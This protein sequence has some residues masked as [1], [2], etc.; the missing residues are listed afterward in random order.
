MR[1]SRHE[2]AASRLTRRARPAEPESS[3]NSGEH[4]SGVGVQ[5]EAV[6]R[7]AQLGAH[8]L[9]DKQASRATPP[10]LS[11]VV[12][13]RRLPRGVST[14][15]LVVRCERRPCCG[16]DDR[17]RPRQH[18]GVER[19]DRGRRRIHNA[20][21][22]R[23]TAGLAATTEGS[24]FAHLRG[25]EP[26]ARERGPPLT[27]ESARRSRTP[28]RARLRSQPDHDPGVVGRPQPEA[29]VRR[30]VA[31][32]PARSTGSGSPL[33]A[34][35]KTMSMRWSMAGQVGV[36]DEL[37]EARGEAGARRARTRSHSSANPPGPVIRSVR[38]R[39]RRRDR[40][41]GLSCRS[42]GRSCSR[43]R[44][45]PGARWRG[46]PGQQLG[47]LPERDQRALRLQV[48]VD[49]AQTL[50]AGADVGPVVAADERE[51][52]RRRSERDPGR[53][54]LAAPALDLTPLRR[55]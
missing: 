7:R 38:R 43:R 51:R 34:W 16:G 4:R 30:V 31:D 26:R 18:S 21:R 44:R 53:V 15:R 6:E 40:S 17:I 39:V 36:V 52:L 32:D 13:N 5:V 3:L 35:P 33:A 9:R 28:V 24:R 42:A 47:R 49:E 2:T 14:R 46:R 8:S 20:V 25:A 41:V 11:Q 12:P 55:A 37:A 29:F 1:T 50:G 27:C 23:A 19:L 48:R 54:L 45:R 22:P 10:S